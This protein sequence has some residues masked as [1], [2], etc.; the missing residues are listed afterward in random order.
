MPPHPVHASFTV[1]WFSHDSWS[2]T[3][4]GTRRLIYEVLPELTAS[5]KA[6]DSALCQLAL[7]GSNHLMEVSLGKILKSFID[8]EPNFTQRHFEDTSYW[9]ALSRWVTTLSGKPIEL[10]SEPFISTE[11]L[12]HRRNATIHKS[13]ALATVAMARSAFF[14][15]IEGSK[16]LHSH[17]GTPFPYESLL[18]QYSHSKEEPFSTVA[19]PF[20]T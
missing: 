3:Y 5:Q 11:R 12:R 13:S 16:A 6:E 1:S 4:L 14:S 2:E 17:F 8:K 15:A 18:K 7:I 19:F 20:G 10:E 9:Q